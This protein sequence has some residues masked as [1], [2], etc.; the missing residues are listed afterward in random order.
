MHDNL[1]DMEKA[2]GVVQ[3]HMLKISYQTS[4]GK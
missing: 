3:S 2:F 4:S 1:K